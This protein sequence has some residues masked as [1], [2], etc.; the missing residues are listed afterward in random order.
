MALYKGHNHCNKD[1]VLVFNEKFIPVIVVQLLVLRGDFVSEAK[2]SFQVNSTKIERESFN[3]SVRKRPSNPVWVIC[4][5]PRYKGHSLEL[6][7]PTSLFVVKQEGYRVCVSLLFKSSLQR[8]WSSLL[9]S[10]RIHA[11]T[12]I[13]VVSELKFWVGTRSIRI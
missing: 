10:W 4:L 9:S 8:S 13:N 2:W 5:Y 11:H 1:S 3:W 7:W 12:R 6:L